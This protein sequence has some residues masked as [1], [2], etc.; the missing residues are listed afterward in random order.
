MGK[1]RN[2]KYSAEEKIKYVKEYLE[3]NITKKG[4]ERAEKIPQR[5]FSLWISRYLEHGEEYFY[6]EHR[7][8]HCNCGNKFAA[9][10]TSKSLTKEERLELEVLKLK[11]ENERL[12]KGY[13]VKGVGANKEFVTF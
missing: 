10:H 8:K 6:E 12:K 13:Q 2:R 4:L 7:G 1:R 3:G 5:T 9:L 11:I